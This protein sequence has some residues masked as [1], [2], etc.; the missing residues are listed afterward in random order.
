MKNVTDDFNLDY[1]AFIK[2]IIENP[3]KYLKSNGLILYKIVEH[4]GIIK[5]QK[6]LAKELQISSKHISRLCKKLEEQRTI[7]RHL[8]INNSIKVKSVSFSDNI[9]RKV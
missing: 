5:S 7:T 3:N 2:I 8:N 6:T 4:H 9:L 1:W